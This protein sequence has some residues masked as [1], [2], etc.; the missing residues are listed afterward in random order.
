MTLV[1]ERMNTSSIFV[2]HLSI[3]FAVLSIAVFSALPSVGAYIL[4][5]ISSINSILPLTPETRTIPNT[6]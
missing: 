6:R 5:I 3:W 1:S 2:T 4:I